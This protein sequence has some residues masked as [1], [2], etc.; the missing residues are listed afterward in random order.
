MIQFDQV[1]FQDG[2][3]PPQVNVFKHSIR[4]GKHKKIGK[5]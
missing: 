1:V 2:L 5:I 3:K 4:F